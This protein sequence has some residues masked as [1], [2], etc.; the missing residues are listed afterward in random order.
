[1]T[2]S[3][4]LAM[5][6]FVTQGGFWV[7]SATL[8]IAM[9]NAGASDLDIG[10]VVGLATVV[11]MVASLAAAAV[12]DRLGVG[13][14]VIGGVACYGIGAVAIGAL[15]EAPSTNS[16]V[17]LLA[18]VLHGTGTA[19]VFP[20]ALALAAGIV[21]VRSSLP[22]ALTAAG[23][24]LS[25]AVFP[26]ISVAVLGHSSLKGVSALACGS[27]VIGLGLFGWTLRRGIIAR[28]PLGGLELT[29]QRDWS[30]PL[31]GLFLVT[32]QWGV[33]QS[34][35]PQRALEA[36]GDPG[37]YFLC[38]GSALLATR[39]VAGW[40]GDNLPAHRLARAGA[41]ML[42]MGAVLLLVSRSGIGLL[43]AGGV[44]GTGAALA[45]TPIVVELGRR[46]RSGTSGSAFALM[47]FA[48]AAA[49]SVGSVAG[50]AL[51][52]LIGF[53]ATLAVVA[54]LVLIGGMTAFSGGG[55]IRPTTGSMEGETR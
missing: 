30:R 7:W 19:L 20:S 24:N 4:R 42:A 44:G 16:T 47:S 3:G 33:I 25:Q 21:V 53:E 36:G 32:I 10:F 48:M 8:P 27:A 14:A 39:L 49:L 6:L 12:I 26:A 2:D 22:L 35:L 17:L 31:V 34:F 38:S 15:V 50:G 43:V 28:G 51:V 40:V 46:S 41:T 29:Y 37:L 13:L 45:I 9:A 11:Q 55:H 1:M 52:E 23:Q 18:R 54:G 5:A